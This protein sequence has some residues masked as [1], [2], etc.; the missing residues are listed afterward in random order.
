M[1]TFKLPNG[2]DWHGQVMTVDQYVFL[3]DFQK[4]QDK[5]ATLEALT[6]SALY[7]SNASALVCVPEHLMPD[8][9][10]PVPA[11]EN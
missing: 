6:L 2:S 7:G 9:D 10:W 1:T 5:K 8:V 4:D 3:L 11:H